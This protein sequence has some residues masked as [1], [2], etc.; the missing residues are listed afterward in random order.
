M[1]TL[2]Y[3]S[4]IL[5]LG[6][7]WSWVVSFTPRPLYPWGVSF[8]AC[9][10]ADWAI[11][12]PRCRGILEKWDMTMWTGLNWAMMGSV[13]RLWWSFDFCDN[14]ECF[15]ALKFSWQWLFRFWSSGLWH[16]VVLLMFQRN[17]TQAS[18]WHKLTF[19]IPICPDQ[20]LSLLPHSWVWV[21]TFYA[22]CLYNLTASLPYSLRP[23]TFSFWDYIAL[24]D[25]MTDELERI[26]KEV[27]MA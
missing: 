11:P 3:S 21:T 9:R 17:M 8:R 27:S 25:R 12:T 13:N 5:D 7:G 2:G 24:D 10:Y 18:V 23:L 20:V 16:C 26:W 15:E 1:K 14:T 4:I 19:I 22:L 6:T